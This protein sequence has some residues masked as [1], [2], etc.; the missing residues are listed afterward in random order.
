[1]SRISRNCEDDRAEPWGFVG[2]SLSCQWTV[3]SKWRSCWPVLRRRWTASPSTGLP[4]TSTGQTDCITGSPS[5]RPNRSPEV[6][7]RWYR[8]DWTSLT[9]S[10]SG[11]R[12]GRL[13]GFWWQ[14]LW[15]ST[16]RTG[17][18]LDFRL[19]SFSY[20]FFFGTVVVRFR[21]Y[22]GFIHSRRMNTWV[23]TVYSFVT[24]WSTIFTRQQI[25]YKPGADWC[26]GATGARRARFSMRRCSANRRKRWSTRIC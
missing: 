5:P 21:V 15:S 11:R 6:I 22:V 20:Q 12:E 13:T 26:S 7:G 24:V 17:H 19:E 25:N 10:P 3:R 2:F 9:A 16:T 23:R 14:R 18:G 1:M 4:G 8:P